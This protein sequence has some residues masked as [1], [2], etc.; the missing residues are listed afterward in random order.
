MITVGSCVDGMKD[1]TLAAEGIPVHERSKHPRCRE[2]QSL[3][4]NQVD[5]AFHTIDVSTPSTSTCVDK[6]R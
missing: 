4:I 6:G 5:D 1:W 2:R 3:L